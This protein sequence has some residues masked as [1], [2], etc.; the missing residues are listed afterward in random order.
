MRCDWIRRYLTPVVTLLLAW[1]TG[2]A[3]RAEEHAG[4]KQPFKYEY[5]DEK[6]EEKVVTVDPENAEQMADFAKRL[7]EGKVGGIEIVQAPPFLNIKWDLGLWSVIVFLGLLFILS[8]VAWKPMLEGLKN[9]EDSIQKALTDAETSKRETA[10]LRQKLQ[11]EMD[12]ATENVRAMIED[13]RRDAQRAADDVLAKAKADIQA[14][15]DRLKREMDIARDQAIKELWEQTATLATQ[16]SSSVVGR[17]MNSDDH[18]RLVDQA[19][20]E[21]RQS[22]SE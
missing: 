6:G 22:A 20:S 11:S 9:R 13:G 1:A 10:E 16:V 8:K 2:S 14:E 15:R 5:H 12:K 19:L 17:Q 21:M 7:K 4:K 3:A 18:R